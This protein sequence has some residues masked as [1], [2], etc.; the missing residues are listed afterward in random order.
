VAAVRALGDDV[1]VL[2]RETYVTFA[3][4]H[5]RAAYDARA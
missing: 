1:E 5:L 4:G 3:R 2:P